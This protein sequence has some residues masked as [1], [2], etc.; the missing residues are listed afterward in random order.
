M[1]EQLQFRIN[2]ILTHEDF[3][4]LKQR[5]VEEAKDEITLL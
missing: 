2:E 5:E 1:D 3:N 4:E